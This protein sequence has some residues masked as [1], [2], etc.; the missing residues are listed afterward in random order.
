MNILFLGNFEAP[1][2]SENHYKATLEKMGHGVQPMQEGKTNY[3]R[4]MDVMTA[5]PFDAF[6]WVHTHGWN[7]PGIDVFLMELRKLKIPSF[8]YHLDLYMGIPREKMLYDHPFFKVDHFFTVDKLM[9]DQMTAW[10]KLG[11]TAKGHFIPAGVLEEHCYL[12]PAN[13]EKYPHDIVFTGAT[14]YHPEWPYRQKLVNWLKETYGDRFAHYG[15]GGLP[16]I[17]GHELNVLYA[18][19]KVVVG[20]TLCKDFNYPWYTSD[21]LFEVCGRGGALVYPQIEGLETFYRQDEH[22]MYYEFGNF[23]QLDIII[24][25]LLYDDDWRSTMKVQAHTH[26]NAEHTY[27][28]RLQSILDTLQSEK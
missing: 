12:A 6:F 8:A 5:L 19:A 20:D 3:D 26:T 25:K 24:N 23:D 16:T 9:A 4:L 13:R 27:R 2:S 7:T 17:R 22:V 28:H 1:E 10:S 21:R 18:S 11:T 14:H 15:P